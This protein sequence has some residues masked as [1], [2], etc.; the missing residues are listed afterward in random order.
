MGLRVDLAE[1]IVNV[2]VVSNGP[3]T[4][5]LS[6]IV[7]TEEYARRPALEICLWSKDKFIV[8]VRVRSGSGGCS[9]FHGGVG[10][11]DR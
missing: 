8:R 6:R 4:R 5:A 7:E 9:L 10:V 2:H 1:D 11:M 3:G